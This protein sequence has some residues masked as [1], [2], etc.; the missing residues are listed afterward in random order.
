MSAKSEQEEATNYWE[1]YAEIW[2]AEVRS[3]KDVFRDLYSTPEFLKFI[4]DIKGK[5]VLDVGCGEGYSTRIFAQHGAHVTGVDFSGIMIKLAREQEE[6]E[7]L[8]ITYEVASWEQ[9]PFNAASFDVVLSTMALMDGPGY[10]Q[11]VQEFYRVLRPQGS[12]FFSVT[13]PCFLTPHYRRLKDEQGETTH[14]ITGEYFNEEPWEFTWNLAKKVDKSDSTVITSINYHRMVSTYI[15]RLVEAGFVLKKI[16]E[17]R[18]SEQ[19]C[20]EN[21]RLNASRDV[22]PSFLFVH[23]MRTH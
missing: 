11:A 2:A 3:G 9:L 12:L 10:E 5:K 6:R 15:N 20:K 8:G 17:P 14:Y 13:H 7:L 4:G 22:A 19:A 16:S 23:G 18:A 1:Q 21:S